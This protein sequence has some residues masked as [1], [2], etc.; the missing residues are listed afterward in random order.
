MSGTRAVAHRP[1]GW[2]IA[3]VVALVLVA[4]VLLWAVWRSNERAKES[5]RVAARAVQA[6]EAANA[7][8]EAAVTSERQLRETIIS[9]CQQRQATDAAG[10]EGRMALQ[11]WFR[12]HIEIE[13]TNPYI[14]DVVRDK[15]IADARKA[16]HGLQAA[17]D[18]A[19][20]SS[21]A[22]YLPK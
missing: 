10:D 2:A 21:C 14:G 8:A 5:Q 22:V 12:S 3:S 4:S 1:H 9:R 11:A 13:R 20:S 19:V 7:V 6:A 17:I 18:K 15:R 16:I